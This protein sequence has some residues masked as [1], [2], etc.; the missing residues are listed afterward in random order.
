M[1]QEGAAEVL[2]GLIRDHPSLKRK[3]PI[4]GAFT[5]PF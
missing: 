2:R 1:M 3:F 4:L 5:S